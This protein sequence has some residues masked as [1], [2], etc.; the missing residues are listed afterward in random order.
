MNIWCRTAHLPFDILVSIHW[1]SSLKHERPSVFI[2]QLKERSPREYESVLV[3]LHSEC[4]ESL[5]SPLR[6]CLLCFPYLLSF[7]LNFGT[8]SSLLDR[9]SLAICPIC[10]QLNL[11]ILFV[12]LVGTA[13][14]PWSTESLQLVSHDLKQCLFFLT[15]SLVKLN[16]V[17]SFS[18]ILFTG[19]IIEDYSFKYVNNDSSMVTFIDFFAT[20]FLLAGPQIVTKVMILISPCHSFASF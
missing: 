14:T 10:L 5:L 19:D 7:L 13:V 9:Q 17:V 20:D 18:C 12:L 2:L 11:W 8:M 16:H 4:F 3:L 15:I 1:S 6:S